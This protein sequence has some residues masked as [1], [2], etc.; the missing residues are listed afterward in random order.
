M[1]QDVDEF[2]RYQ[3]QRALVAAICRADPADAAQIMAA[4]LESL[5]AGAPAPLPRLFENLR[6]EAAFWAD[7][8]H[9]IELEVYAAAALRRIERRAFCQGARKRL[10]LAL[11]KSMPADW[12]RAFVGRVD[13][14]GE[15][16]GRAA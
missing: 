10:L 1:V 5:S 12:R 14:R 8:A 2:A 15:Y 6:E 16:T 13:P 11:W 3:A 4:A 9:P 7:S